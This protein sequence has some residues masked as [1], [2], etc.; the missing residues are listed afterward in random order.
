MGDATQARLDAAN[1]DRDAGKGFARALGI[2]DDGVI[3][4]ASGV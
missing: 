1:N 4:A 3:G 2:D